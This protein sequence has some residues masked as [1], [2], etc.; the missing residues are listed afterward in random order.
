MGGN[1][2]FIRQLFCFTGVVFLFISLQLILPFGTC[3]DS[4]AT[5]VILSS[6]QDAVSIA[7]K[8]NKDI[9]IQEEEIEVA[10]ANILGAKSAFLPK[11]NASA[12]YTHN[13]WVFPLSSATLKKDIGIFAGY[14]N[15]NK[16]G[17]SI[18][19]SI[20]NGGANIA[21]LKQ[22]QLGLKVQEETLRANKLDVE[23]ETK[24]LYYGLLLAYETERITQALV[25][26]AKSHYEDVKEKFKEDTASRF[27]TLQSKI[28]VSK[29]IPELIKA[30]NAVDL[31][32]ADLK[33][34]LGF[35]MRDS[36]K[37]SGVPKDVST[38]LLLLGA[39]RL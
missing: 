4:N 2:K 10:R 22:A 15:T 23:F 26:Q 28:Q 3:D 35:K 36:I 31:I 9:Q 14:K 32:M 37:I 33:K 1:L 17:I 11:L 21:N 24:R 38:Q 16:F 30:R 20:Y 34:L 39:W 5:G 7:F 27:D 13:A 19:E 18:D 25:D 8:N 29:L 12:G 6:L